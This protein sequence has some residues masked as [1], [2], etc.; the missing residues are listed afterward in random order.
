MLARWDVKDAVFI[1]QF[2]ISEF[3]DVPEAEIL[4]SQV[5]EAQAIAGSL[6]W[7]STRTRPDL[8]FGVA[9]VCRLTTK[10]PV[11][12][13][14]IGQLLLKYIKGSPGY[15]HYPAGVPNKW[16][17]QNQ[18]K[19]QRHSNLIEVFAGISYATGSGHKSVQGLVLCF[20]GCPVAWQ[21]S[22]QPFVT[23]STAESKLVAY[24]E[25]LVS[26]R[27]LEAL[28]CALWGQKLESNSF[29]RVIYGD[30]AAAISLAHG[31]G[32]TSWRTRHLRV[33]ASMLREALTE[34]SQYPGGLWKLI[35]L[36]GT[37]L[38]A[39]GTTKPLCG[40]AFGLFVKELG[41]CVGS[42]P[43]K[44]VPAPVSGGEHRN[45]AVKSMVVGSLL[46]SAA[47]AH[48]NGADDSS[49]FSMMWT[50]GV[51]L[52]ALGAVYIGQLLHSSSQCCLKR[53]RVLSES[54]LAPPAD[55]SGERSWS[56]D[57][58]VGA[59][60][61]NRRGKG[62]D[63]WELVSAASEVDDPATAE[64]NM[65]Q[66]SLPQ[67]GFPAAVSSGPTS[68]RLLRQSGSTSAVELSSSSS[69]SLPMCSQ[70]GLAAAVHGDAA[71]SAAGGSGVAAGFAAGGSGDAAGLA[72]GGSGV[73]A[74]FAA[75]GSGDAAGLAAGGSGDA[76]G[77]AAGGS[78]GVA[79]TSAGAAVAAAAERPN[80]VVAVQDI[81]IPNPWNRFQ[82]QHKGKGWN[83]TRMRAEY[84]K[85][86]RMP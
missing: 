70:S 49:D 9:A 18:L 68:L 27:S 38:V 28:V 19:L 62:E 20:A 22:S 10:N 61:R 26:G 56:F 72:A 40:V 74:G 80:P 48:D 69:S 67:S 60:L 16:G 86:K 81:Q 57:F 45:L 44:H 50:G 51:I 17:T 65:S 76:A 47:E 66:S 4:P 59:S 34:D 24:C 82:S 5:K 36:R 55:G 83:M 79:N 46:L 25:S 11:R 13:I 39:D 12:A 15:L 1:P 7:L 23:H 42:T 8:T 29:D 6:L 32:A 35:H 75:G 84:F 52:M 2:K 85:Q 77:L 31:T 43:V 63:E 14:E 41:L 54:F 78:S 3:D 21:C 33:R 53:L 71:G 30:N 64:Q 37:E 58:R 73:A